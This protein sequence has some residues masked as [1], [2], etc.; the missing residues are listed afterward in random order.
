LPGADLHD[1]IDV[2]CASCSSELAD[3][4]LLGLFKHSPDA[5][6]F[7]DG[8]GRWLVANQVGLEI[9]HLN[10]KPYQGKTDAELTELA[11]P[12]YREAFLNCHVSDEAVWQL[13]VLSRVE[14]VIP[15]PEGGSKTFEVIK[16]PLFKEDGSRHGLMVLGRDVTERKE[17]ETNL[18]NRSAILDALISSD[19]LLHSS[20]SWQKI[21]PDILA[22]LGAASGFSRVSLFH[23]QS[24]KVEKPKISS[25]MRWTA[26]DS[27]PFPKALLHLDYESSGCKRWIDQLRQGQAVFGTRLSFHR[28]ELALLKKTGYAN[29][30]SHPGIQR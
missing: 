21:A 27:P 6:Y 29:H 13:G 16:L 23:T 8:E 10:D 20:E 12:L 11:H 22:M 26:P 25:V 2:L 18:S 28:K 24:G 15:L 9:F 1:A 7:K 4:L 3:T 17:A 30:H 5:V 14:E 19:W